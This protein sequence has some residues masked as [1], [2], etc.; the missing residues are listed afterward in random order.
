MGKLANIKKKAKAIQSK[1]KKAVKAIK[2]IEGYAEHPAY[3]I[4]RGIGGKLGSASIGGGIGRAIGKITGTGDYAMRGNSIYSRNEILS[5]DCVPQFGSGSRGTRV[6]HREYLGDVVASSVANAFSVTSYPINPGLNSSFPWLA[7]FANQFDE[8]KP[9]GIVYVFKSMS[10]EFGAGTASLGRVI[11]ATD[12]DVMDETYATAIEMEN[13][14]FAVS[15]KCSNSI[16]HPVECQVKERFGPVLFTRSGTVPSTDNAR[17]FDLGNFQIATVGCEANQLVGE[18]WVTWDIT[19]YK[20]QLYG[21]NLGRSL[22]FANFQLASTATGADMFTS[23]IANVNNTAIV[24]CVGNTITFP[25][26]Y[27]GAT[28]CVELMVKG[29]GTTTTPIGPATYT[30]GMS[31][32]AYPYTDT[33][34]GAIISTGTGSQA[35]MWFSRLV[36]QIASPG[37]ASTMVFPSETFPTTPLV[38]SVLFVRQVNPSEAS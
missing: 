23:S 10:S 31:A 7:P 25:E 9:N 6:Q 17:F 4:G 36:K 21:G 18:L 1:A 11:M 27:A 8:W 14:Q 15:T 33:V 37:V 2:K 26:Q 32:V 35:N 16:V 3:S 19:L 29:T 38:S 28:W 22:L 5:G 12:Y 13:S 20:P 30:G 34:S 24:T